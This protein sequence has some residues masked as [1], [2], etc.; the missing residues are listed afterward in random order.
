MPASRTVLRWPTLWWTACFI[1]LSV[2]GAAPVGGS[3]SAAEPALGAASDSITALI[4]DL[5]A[6]D[7]ASRERAQA[8]LRRLG[9]EAFDH[10]YAAQSS[11]DIEIA[12]R[13]RYL[14]RSLNIR[15]FQDDDPLPVRELLRAYSERSE[16][17]RQSLV[18]QLARMP[19][20][21]GVKAIC[22]IVRFEES[23]A[24]SKRAALAVMQRKVAAANPP[25]A[26]LAAT[27]NEALGA[28]RREAATWLRAYAVALRDPAETLADWDRISARE[29]Q[30]YQNTPD[31]S[32]PDIVRDLFRWRADLLER[33][34]RAEESQAVVRKTI[35]LLDGT[36]EQ[37]VEAV[38]WLLER[39]AWATIVEVSQRFPE[40]F[41]ES[42]MLLYRLAEAQSRNGQQAEAEQ[43]AQQA[44]ASNQAD[45]QEHTEAALSLQERGLFAWA[46]REYRQVLQRVTP[47]APEGLW[48]RLLFSEMLHDLQ[49][50]QDAAAVLR[51]IVDAAERDE[52]VRYL[53]VRFRNQP[54]SVAARMHFFLAEHA[55]ANG[56]PNQQIEHLKKAIRLDPTDADV[57][58]GMYRASDSDPAWRK[59][60]LDLVSTAIQG[61]REEVRDYEG[62][63]AEAPTEAHRADIYRD[64][65]TAHNQ[66][67]WLI[68]NT[69]GDYEEALRSS[70][71]SL[72]LRPEN[73]GYLDTLGR[74]YYAKGDYRNAVVHQA[75]AVELDPH[76][77]QILRQLELFKQA[78]DKQQR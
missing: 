62:Q 54:G 51:E 75:R 14:L 15:W 45:Q 39:H 66:L 26:S 50:D 41:R 57:L 31:R 24:L 19:D 38:D 2:P 11:D 61:F 40:R 44:L 78:A 65:A 9:L 7:Y 59:E 63:A 52:T 20:G 4:R 32:T 72:E 30:V 71:R 68:A 70:L 23:N 67:A 18:E 43:T 55:R 25:P 33:L 12:L 27:I 17:E 76:S 35:D 16:D 56:D 64:L 8:R 29:E 49:R 47:A 77:G 21:Q 53:I 73:A 13:A 42:A 48:A 22:R 5:G 69:E 37:L 58:I 1:Y 74:C 3:D 28:S 46:E 60:T 10:L 6:G 36:R 34:G